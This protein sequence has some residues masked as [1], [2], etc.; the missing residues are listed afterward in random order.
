MNC[1]SPNCSNNCATEVTKE[2]LK[3]IS[4]FSPL[5]RIETHLEGINQAFV[6]SEINTC[7]RKIHFLAQVMHESGGLKYTK[8]LGTNETSYGGFAGRGLIQL[9][10]EENY[11]KYGEFV[12]EDLTSSLENKTKLE[13]PPHAARSAGWFWNSRAKLNRYADTNDFIMITRLINGGFNGYDDRLKYLQNG[14]KVFFPNETDNTITYELSQSAAFS[15]IKTCFAWALWH[16][17]AI[18]KKGC[19]K[20]ATKAMEGYE[21]V[22]ALM[23]SSFS[24]SNWYGIHK[25]T[26]FGLINNDGVVQVRDAAG[27]RFQALRLEV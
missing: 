11:K 7:L 26:A 25:L 16:D 18:P 15:D 2:D 22:L 19:T 12:G 8:E 21:R 24:A 3:K 27:L 20:S 4:P 9:T 14:L 6:E 23:D 5:S 1:T 10:W 17:P 13:Q